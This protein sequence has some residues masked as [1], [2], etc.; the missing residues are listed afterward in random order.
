MEEIDFEGLKIS[1]L[2]VN[3]YFICKRKM[4]LFDRKITME[5]NSEK[6]LLGAILHEISYKKDKPKEVLIDNL[7]SVDILDNFNIREV[8]YSDKMEKADRMQILYYLYYLKKLGIHKKGIIN[9]PKQRKREFVELKPED[10]K[11]I[12]K[13]LIQINKIL[14][15]KKPPPVIDEPYCKKCAYFEFCYG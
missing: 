12:E 4:W 1:G 14:K 10:E 7:I 9:Y 5:K 13:V 11:E 15:Q 8:K 3:Y 2:K 6:V